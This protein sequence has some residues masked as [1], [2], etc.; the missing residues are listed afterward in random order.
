MGEGVSVGLSLEGLSSTLSVAGLWQTSSVFADWGFCV[1]GQST[2]ILKLEGIERVQRRLLMG[3]HR[4]FYLSRGSVLAAEAAG[5]QGF[6]LTGVPVCCNKFDKRRFRSFTPGHSPQA[7][8]KKKKKEALPVCK[9]MLE[10]GFL[11]RTEHALPQNLL[12]PMIATRPTSLPPK[13]P[14]QFNPPYSEG[15]QLSCSH[16]VPQGNFCLPQQ[17]PAS[18]PVTDLVG[19]STLCVSCAMFQLNGTFVSKTLTLTALK[20]L[21]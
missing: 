12:S 14:S 13:D 21:C 2:G 5:M 10:T 7:K 20:L 9:Q 19:K 17:F 15:R 6:Q 8:K 18:S 16:A 4:D 1:F 3:V 11:Q